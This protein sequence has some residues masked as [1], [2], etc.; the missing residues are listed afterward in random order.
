MFAG[1]SG[2]S[3]FSG[4][5]GA[6]PNNGLPSAPPPH[7]SS[8]R[9]TAFIN[10]LRIMTMGGSLN[11]RQRAAVKDAQSYW[12]YVAKFHKVPPPPLGPMLRPEGSAPDTADTADTEGGDLVIEEPIG[13]DWFGMLTTA[14][15][16]AGVGYGGWYAYKK[17]GK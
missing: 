11:A 12:D 4:H 10:G 1:L 16:V 13:A 5:F 14:A 8:W 15:I 3:T 6:E 9:K 17:W 2:Y 7:W